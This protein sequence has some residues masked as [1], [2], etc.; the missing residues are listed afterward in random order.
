MND[1]PNYKTD[2]FQATWQAVKN[3]YPYFEF[4]NTNWDSIYFVYKPNIA[5][6]N[7]D[8]Y[9]A[10]L[11]QILCELKDGHVGL[12]LLD[13][14]YLGYQTPRQIKDREAF[15][16]NVTRKYLDD[17][18]CGL[19]GGQIAHATINNKIEYVYISTFS[20]WDSHLKNR[21]T[22][23]L[24]KYSTQ[25]D[26]FI[27]DVRHNGGGSEIYSDGLISHFISDSLQKPGYYYQNKFGPGIFI[28][29]QLP[30][31]S[32]KQI[33]VL[34]NGKSFS[35]T[36]HFV[37]VMQQLNNTTI[38]GDTTAGGS[39]NPAYYDLPSGMKVRISRVN[40]LQYNN[41]PIEWNGIVPNIVISQT[42]DDILTETDKQLEFA[43]EYLNQL[44]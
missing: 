30:Y 38:I 11:H 29:S 17:N 15:N 36:E 33:V 2:D 32:K 1:Q 7:G 24:Q 6:A 21:L 43:I 22:D 19:P 5:T 40:Y 20:E 28:Y 34:C 16:F 26:K 10:L 3:T 41:T 35:A 39:G 42:K 23:T 25:S 4:K 12:K 44:R 9:I 27:I 37:M 13:G 14:S 18:Y 31:L 8:E